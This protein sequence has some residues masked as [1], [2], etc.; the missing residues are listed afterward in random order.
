[1]V[2]ILANVRI[3]YDL[4]YWTWLLVATF[5][6]T[7]IIPYIGFMYVASLLVWEFGG[8]FQEVFMVPDFYVVLLISA[9]FGSA[10]QAAFSTLSKYYF[11]TTV[12]F[13]RKEAKRMESQT[14]QQDK[15]QCKTALLAPYHKKEA[16]NN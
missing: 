1:M 6:L 11:P 3:A 8:T 14:M 12:D 4:T 9:G 7:S 2:L 16:L 10:A 5:F 13:V 15:S